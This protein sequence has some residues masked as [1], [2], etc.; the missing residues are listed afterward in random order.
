MIWQ[1]LLN[2]TPLLKNFSHVH[3]GQR[4]LCLVLL[5]IWFFP[6]PLS[7]ALS[8]AGG[9]GRETVSQEAGARECSRCVLGFLSQ[10]LLSIRCLCREYGAAPCCRYTAAT[11]LWARGSHCYPVLQLLSIPSYFG[12][13]LCS[14]GDLCCSDLFSTSLVRKGVP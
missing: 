12:L 6:S 14:P 2:G 4:D 3:L 7:S 1:N 8:L 9:A 10:S 13:L 5:Q 11:H